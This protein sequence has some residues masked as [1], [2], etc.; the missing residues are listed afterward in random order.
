MARGTRLVLLVLLAAVLG[1]GSGASRAGDGASQ[2]DVSASPAGSSLVI[3]QVYGGGGNAGATYDHDFI[4]VHNT[5]TSP[6]DLAGWSVQY[7][8]ATGTTWSGKT[9]LSGTVPAGRY[10]LVE[11]ATGGAHGSPLPTPDLSGNINLSATAGK[12]ALVDSTTALG[13]GACTEDPSVIDLVGY[14]VANCSETSPAPAPSATNADIRAGSGCTDTDDNSADFAASAANPRN[15]TITPHYCQLPAVSSTTPGDSATGVAVGSSLSVTFNEPVDLADGWYT[16]SCDTS[17]SHT[18]EVSGG[19]TTFT[20]DPDAD[21]AHSELCTT[22]VVAADVSVNG[23][24]TMASD[25]VFTFTTA[26]APAQYEVTSTDYAPVAGRTVAIR[27]Q[28]AD[29]DGNPV[30]EEG[31]T[32][33][34]S[35]TGGGQ[36]SDPQSTTNSS[37]VASV[38]FTT[39]TAAGTV[40]TVT[41]TDGAES[42]IAGT[43][44]DIT[45]VP[46][47]FAKLQLLVP[48]ETAAPGT[49]SGKTGTPTAHTAGSVFTVTVRGVDVHWNKVSTVTDT[50]HLASSDSH[51]VLPANAALVSGQKF[52]SVKLKTAGAPR[53]VA[54]DV[55]TPA[56]RGSSSPAITIEPGAFVKLLLLVPGQTADPG[57]STGRKGIPA[58]HVA[59]TSFTVTV[60][61][62]DAYWNRV[63]TATDLVHIGSSDPHA[64]LPPGA[65]LVSG[66][67][68]IAIT[69]K[70]AGSTTRVYALD[71]TN[72]AKTKSISPA[73]TVTPAAPHVLAFTSSTAPLALGSSR[74]LTV[75]V[76][77]AYG[78]RV[79]GDSG[80]TVTFAKASGAG[81]VS[82]LGTSTTLTGVAKKAVKA[83]RAGS[84][85]ISAS[86]SGLLGGQTAFTITR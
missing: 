62:V 82:G 76:R 11:E 64:A 79:K 78:N 8:S 46:G 5:G 2:A 45:T 13:N 37:G 57:S 74:T 66:S 9:D 23:S 25:Y 83:T 48:G 50:V 22:T 29:A 61:G 77:D 1:G 51:A 3:S 34:W 47:P 86:A 39:S 59:G 10:F 38:H 18:A 41:A 73:I 33:I 53:V 58:A 63:P 65:A 56:K 19:P 42:S 35:R 15:T 32:V 44:A 6:V 72:A 40:H 36:L 16:I 24:D 85:T 14:G 68:T 70:T 80:R 7:A 21:F 31:R 12:V 20:I 30:A 54:T 4:E 43:S 26:A 55:T 27:A 28:L 67:K 60:K 75:E 69:L 52:F 49:T 17:G 81:T 84:I 71:V